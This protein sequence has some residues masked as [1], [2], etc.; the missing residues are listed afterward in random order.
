MT[1][2]MLEKMVAAII[3]AGP[4]GCCNVSD[5]QARFIARAALQAIREPSEEM[6][7]AGV[8]R[9]PAYLDGDD[10]KYAG[11]VFTA[12]IDAILSETN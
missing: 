3:D 9:L 8:T 10:A 11:Y 4:V 5:L 6:E 2:K 12:M 1:D 7:G